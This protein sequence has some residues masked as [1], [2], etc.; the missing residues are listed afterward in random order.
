[1]V[2]TF[3][4]WRR[5]SCR[6]ICIMFLLKISFAYLLTLYVL[7]SDV[8]LSM[9][10]YMLGYMCVCQRTLRLSLLFPPLRLRQGVCCSC[11]A[12]YPRPAGPRAVGDSPVYTS[13]LQRSA[14]IID[15]HQHVQLFYMSLNSGHQTCILS[16][17][18]PWAIL[19]AL[20]SIAR[21]CWVVICST[22]Y[23]NHKYILHKRQR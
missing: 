6:W 13:Y 22:S 15:T 21:E 16:S 23:F 1:M 20:C 17:F 12:A 18:T 5:C 8:V 4:F 3:L 19:S 7:A 14:T 9:D 10:T 2:W 11:H